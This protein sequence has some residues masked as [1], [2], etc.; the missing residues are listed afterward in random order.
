MYNHNYIPF[1]KYLIELTRFPV[2]LCS[3][4]DKFKQNILLEFLVFLYFKPVSNAF[5]SN[6][7]G[8]PR[9]FMTS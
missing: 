2:F 6:L 7:H 3:I 5:R 8:I 1:S 9:L 4:L